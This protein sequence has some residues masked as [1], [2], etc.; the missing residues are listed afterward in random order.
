MDL[1]PIDEGQLGRVGFVK[2]RRNLLVISI[3]LSAGLWAGVSFEPLGEI[4][5][6]GHKLLL[7]TRPEGIAHRLDSVVVFSYSLRRVSS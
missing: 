4:T 5:I 7:L 1:N 3:L 6:Y 2:Q